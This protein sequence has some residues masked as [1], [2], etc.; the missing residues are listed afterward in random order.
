MN[1]EKADKTKFAIGYADPE[2]ELMVIFVPIKH[3]SEIEDGTA[4]VRGKL[5]EATGV[6]LLKIQELRNKKSAVGI[7]KPINGSQRPPN[8]PLNVA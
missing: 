4:L 5:Q 3:Y 7:I 1:E 6:I 2:A 8:I